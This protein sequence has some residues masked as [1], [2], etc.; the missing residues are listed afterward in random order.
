MILSDPQT[1]KTSEFIVV[2]PMSEGGLRY[3]VISKETGKETHFADIKLMRKNTIIQVHD[4]K[5]GQQMIITSNFDRTEYVTIDERGIPIAKIKINMAFKPKIRIECESEVIEGEGE[6]IG[7]EFDFKDEE[8]N[9][10][11]TINKSKVVVEDTFKVKFL[12]TMDPKIPMAI[13]MCLDDHF[14]R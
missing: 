7:Q 8:G 13:A 12:N 3:R 5:F 2:Q 9:V 6:L 11:I 14:Y 1:K 4:S 10:V